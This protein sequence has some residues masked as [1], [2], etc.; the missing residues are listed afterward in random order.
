MPNLGWFR[1]LLAGYQVSKWCA[2]DALWTFVK[3]LFFLK[4]AHKQ[5]TCGCQGGKRGGGGKG[6]SSVVHLLLWK[7]PFPLTPNLIMGFLQDPIWLLGYLWRFSILV[8]SFNHWTNNN[9]TPTRCQAS[10]C[11]LEYISEQHKHGALFQQG[12]RNNNQHALQ[13]SRSYSV[14]GDGERWSKQKE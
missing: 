2:S 7:F 13:V 5:Q 12:E 8:I 14:S 3:L 1:G 11:L 10:V 6:E 4:W 9:G